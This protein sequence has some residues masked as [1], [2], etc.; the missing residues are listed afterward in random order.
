MKRMVIG[1]V[2]SLGLFAFACGG[3]ISSPECTKYLTCC[4][5]LGGTSASACET[6]YG[7][8][9][10]CKTNSTTNDACEAGCKAGYDGL[11]TSVAAADA[12]TCE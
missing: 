6:S 12:G 5:K 7:D 8:N 3:G 10:T 9:S 2:A 1:V 4:K 11:K